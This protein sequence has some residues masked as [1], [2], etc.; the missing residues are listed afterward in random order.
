M[1]DRTRRTLRPPTLA[2]LSRLL[3]AVALLM[4]G[5]AHAQQS[6]QPAAEARLPELQLELFRPATGPTDYYN[7][8]SSAVAPHLA[9]DFGAWLDYADDPLQVPSYGQQFNPV[10]DAQTTLSLMGNVG[11]FDRF[12]VGVLLPVTLYQSSRSLEPIDLNSPPTDRDE[13][14]S[15]GIN[16]IR[17]SA[18]Y[19]ILDLLR[20]DFG[21][22]VVLAGYIPTGLDQRLG[23]DAGFGADA[24]VAGEYWL[25]RGIRV[26]ANLGYRYRH[27]SQEFRDSTIGDAVLWG[28]AANVPLFI[29]TLDAV[30]EID[31]AVGL[32]EDPPGRGGIQA[33]EVPAELRI[34]A[35]YALNRDWTLS[36]GFGSGLNDE[37]V[38]TPDLR[39]FLSINGRWVSGGDWGFDYDGDGI[40]GVY[41]KCPGDGEDFDG[42]QDL[43]GCP[44]DD[45]DG[46]SVP[47]DEDRCDNTPEGVMVGSDGCPDNDLDGDGIPN[48]IDACPE[49]PEDLDRFQDRDGCP[50]VDN[51]GDGL[52]DTAD[53]CP[54]EPE[55]FND[56]LD[57]DG[58]PDD[59]NDKVH[60]SRDKIIITEQVHFETGKATIKRE[61]Y[62]ILDAVIEVLKANPQVQKLR[63]EGHTDSRGS[64]E[65]NRQLSQDR[66]DSVRQYLVERGIAERRLDAIGY[67]E[68]QPIASNET[69]E[70]RAL[71]RRVEFTIVEM[72][73]Y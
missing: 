47:D 39:V 6:A 5:L 3:L 15:W 25:V 21:L 2:R 62:D 32:S 7:V 59:P 17:L 37:A 18:K 24:I 72:Q 23:G 13:L 43:D 42:H 71:N 29:S 53:T 49:D 16:D 22:G 38:G 50:D 61:S 1:F 52:P 8:Y 73:E 36:G 54:M 66:A 9:W 51:D 70:G 34:G 68:A 44:E 58:C 41:D 33:G 12:E 20:D 64:D 69:S 30:L 4:P 35:R 10:V 40:Y 14:A 27:A 11:L 56:F 19:Q 60:L 55:T 65:L 26:A 46:D 31:G 67:G 48:D 57:D 63:I 28:L 45:N